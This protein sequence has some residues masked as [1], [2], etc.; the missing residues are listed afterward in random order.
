[1]EDERREI[2]IAMRESGATLNDIASRV[3]A[4]KTTVHMWCGNMQRPITVKRASD[5]RNG[6]R[7]GKW[8]SMTDP[9]MAV[10]AKEIRGRETVI[11]CMA[12]LI[13]AMSEKKEEP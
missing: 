12:R 3:K 1:M 2:A 8:S 6:F 4:S 11:A 9:A 7:L 13:V 10:V 5:S